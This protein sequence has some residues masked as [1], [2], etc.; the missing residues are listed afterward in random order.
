MSS[1]LVS[2]LSWSSQVGGML[3]GV[4]DGSFRGSSQK[5]EGI[6]MLRDARVERNCL[7]KL[8]SVMIAVLELVLGVGDINTETRQWW[9]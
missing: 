3:T 5:S 2:A 6:R 4:R 1:R 9:G 7:E 8:S